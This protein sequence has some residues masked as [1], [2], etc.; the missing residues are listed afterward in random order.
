VWFLSSQKHLSGRGQAAAGSLP[1][2]ENEIVAG[3]GDKRIRYAA[4]LESALG[5]LN[6]KALT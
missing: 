5:I 1:E 6:A 2:S 4:C 3:K